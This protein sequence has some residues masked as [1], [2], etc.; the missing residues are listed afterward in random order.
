MAFESND[1][2]VRAGYRVR[3]NPSFNT[4]ASDKAA[5]A[6]YVKRQAPM[7][8]RLIVCSVVAFI[9]GAVASAY[10]IIDLHSDQA[11]LRIQSEAIDASQH[12]LK[13]LEA[14]RSNKIEHAIAL[15]ED[16]LQSEIV[17]LSRSA[18]PK[19]ECRRQVLIKRIAVY[20]STYPYSSGHPEVDSI[21]TKTLAFKPNTDSSCG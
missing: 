17:M 5:G 16:K 11:I 10:L 15:L 13:V 1:A 20:R 21:V 7:K 8:L 18:D 19:H 4:D 6:G 2:S 3:A 14:I 9:V 12:Q